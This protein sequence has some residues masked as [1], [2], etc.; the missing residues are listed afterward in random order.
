M[1]NSA[2][3]ECLTSYR[4]SFHRLNYQRWQTTSWF[5]LINTFPVCYSSLIAKS[6]N[7]S[8][9]IFL[10]LRLSLSLIF[11][12]LIYIY[13]N[14]I[15]SGLKKNAITWKISA[16]AETEC[17]GG[18]RC[19]LYLL[20]YTRVLRMRLWIFSPGWNFLSITWGISARWTGLKISSRVAQTRLKFQPGSPGW[21]FLHVIAIIGILGWTFS[22][23]NQAKSSFWAENPHQISP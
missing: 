1:R 14:K 16:W 18:N 4:A 21:N 15:F 2:G 11:N 17:E 12:N 22:L 9:L 20:L 19:F 5:M 13:V 10:S 8:E 3:F 6:E 7:I 23:V